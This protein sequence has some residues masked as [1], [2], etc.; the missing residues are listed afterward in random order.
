MTILNR[1]FFLT[2][3]PIW[4]QATPVTY[5][6]FAEKWMDHHHSEYS[7]EEKSAFV[8]G[9]VFPDIRYLNIRMPK[10]PDPMSISYDQVVSAETPFEKGRLFHYY[11]SRI[12]NEIIASYDVYNE[13]SS[14]P[15]EQRDLLLMLLED[16]TYYEEIDKE[17]VKRH[18][19]KVIE[20]EEYTGVPHHTLRTWHRIVCQ[21][22]GMSPFSIVYRLRQFGFGMFGATKETVAEWSREFPALLESDTFQTYIA[23]LEERFTHSLINPIDR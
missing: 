3:L 1:L 2:L 22:Y 7:S 5:V 4:L 6:Y 21:Y 17:K 12:R 14:V 13:L 19:S 16:H 18:F 9:V 8:L 11:F 20:A 10:E 23:T 15:T